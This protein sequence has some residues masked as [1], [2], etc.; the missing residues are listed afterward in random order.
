MVGSVRWWRNQEKGE[1][2]LSDRTY[3]IISTRCDLPLVA[4]GKYKPGGEQ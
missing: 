2:G 1:D 3:G 4:S